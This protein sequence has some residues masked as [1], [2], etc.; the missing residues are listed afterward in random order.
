MHTVVADVDFQSDAG[1]GCGD[2]SSSSG[3]AAEDLKDGLFACWDM[4]T[5]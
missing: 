2:A 4:L 1:P 3:R 5:R